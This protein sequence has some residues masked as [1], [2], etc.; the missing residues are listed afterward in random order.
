V[1]SLPHWLVAL[2]ALERLAELVISRRNTTRLLKRGACEL[3]AGHY[4]FIV[5]VHVS[6]IAAL[7]LSVPPNAALSWPW[8]LAYLLLQAGRTWVMLT[9]GSYWTTRIIHL[10]DEPLI[11]AGPYRFCRHP[12]Y[13][14]VTGEIAV[15]PLVFGLWQ[16]A[17]LFSIANAAVLAWRVSVENNALARRPA[18]RNPQ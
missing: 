1:I 4:P 17:I 6:W 8:L 14:V 11:G 15:L 18:R 3:G 2:V 10:P 16:Q 7:W 12:N 5:A 9:L 13:V